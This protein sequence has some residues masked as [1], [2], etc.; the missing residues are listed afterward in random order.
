MLT[1][2]KKKN[3]TAQVLAWLL[4]KVLFI[5]SMTTPFWAFAEIEEHFSRIFQLP[6]EEILSEL[7]HF[8]R[9][10]NGSFNVTDS[11]GYTLLH[12][13]VLH[14]NITA[15]NFIL[16]FDVDVNTPYPVSI[17]KGTVYEHVKWAKG[18]RNSLEERG[19]VLIMARRRTPLHIVERLLSAGMNLHSINASPPLAAAVGQTLVSKDVVQTNS[20]F[21][22]EEIH[23]RDPLYTLRLAELLLKFKADVNA[24]D[25]EGDTALHIA[26]KRGSAIDVKIAELLLDHR[27]RLD[28]QNNQGRRPIQSAKY[29]AGALPGDSS[30]SWPW[31]FS[32]F[33]K[34]YKI[35]RLLQ[36]AEN[37][38]LR[39]A[40]IGECKSF[41]KI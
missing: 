36:R 39:A 8:A 6:Q 10:H 30:L 24:Q 1:F 4:L 37:S 26:A 11:Q 3:S 16:N 19:P 32:F 33:N 28:I 2:I 22:A 34:H 40:P 23:Q 38:T 17:Y 12:Q 21:L 9:R 18:G 7:R 5:Q 15:V 41:I 29:S 27:A 20:H 35:I 14:N 31:Y 13:A 25:Q